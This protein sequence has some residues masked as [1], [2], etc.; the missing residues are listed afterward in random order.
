MKELYFILV[1]LAGLAIAIQTGVNAQL[2]VLLKNPVFTSLVSFMVGTFG[3]LLFILFTDRNALV[4]QYPNLQTHWWKY[5]GGLLGAF[6]ISVIVIVAPR[7]GAATTIG[8]AVASQLI[9]AVIFDHYGWLGF[10]LK[11]VSLA[12]ILGVILLIAGVYLIRKF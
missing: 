7:L 2:N 3:L 4:Q 1:I 12:R 8:F 11:E 9:F 5:T 10:P 6:Y